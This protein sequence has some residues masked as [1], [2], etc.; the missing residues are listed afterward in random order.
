MLNSSPHLE[1]GLWTGLI[2]CCPLKMLPAM[3]ES[4]T[5]ASP[6]PDL[7]VIRDPKAL[8]YLSLHVSPAQASSPRPWL[9]KT[10]EGGGREDLTSGSKLPRS[11]SAK[12][13][14]MVTL[15]GQS[16]PLAPSFSNST[17]CGSVPPTSTEIVLEVI[18]FPTVKSDGLLKIFILLNFSA[19]YDNATTFSPSF[20]IL[21]K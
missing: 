14:R 10:K 15:T 1:S 18:G 8:G 21:M 9:E 16:Q 2:H 12:A 5:P 13:E 20:L 3:P 19:V 11:S 6:L 17:R 4:P 7:S